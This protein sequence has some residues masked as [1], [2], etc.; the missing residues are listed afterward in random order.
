MAALDDSTST[1]GIPASV[2]P[3]SVV[4][5]AVAHAV[6]DTDVVAEGADEVDGY[7]GTSSNLS[8]SDFVS[9][10]KDPESASF[11]LG[12]VEIASDVVPRPLMTPFGGTWLE[13]A[14]SVLPIVEAGGNGIGR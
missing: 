9:F 4:N 13:A 2:L 8:P 5:D 12:A 11:I 6:G 1:T 3:C 7:L 10:G 14:D